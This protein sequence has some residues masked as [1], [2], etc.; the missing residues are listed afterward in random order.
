MQAAS[1]GVVGSTGQS[2][3]PSQPLVTLE[4][5]LGLMPPAGD[6]RG[7]HA[8]F[9]KAAL[10]AKCA[11]VRT[12]P[13]LDDS[14]LM[15]GHE[16]PQW[17]AQ[18]SCNKRN[19]VHCHLD[20]QNSSEQARTTKGDEGKPFASADLRSR[21]VSHGRHLLQ[22]QQASD[23]LPELVHPAMQD[24]AAAAAVMEDFPSQMLPSQSHLAAVRTHQQPAVKHEDTGRLVQSHDSPLDGNQPSQP[25]SLAHEQ[26]AGQTYSP[27][28]PAGLGEVYSPTV[29]AGLDLSMFVLSPTQPGP[30]ETAAL[31]PG[32]AFTSDSVGPPH[33]QH[34]GC[35]ND[36][37][38]AF[39]PMDTDVGGPGPSL[40]GRQDAAT[41]KEGHG[42]VFTDGDLPIPS[43]T[44]AVSS[45]APAES[46]LQQVTATRVS[47]LIITDSGTD[48]DFT[49]TARCSQQ[50]AASG[51]QPM[52]PGDSAGIN[53]PAVPA[54]TPDEAAMTTGG[55]MSFDRAVNHSMDMEPCQSKLADANH[56]TASLASQ[57]EATNAAPPCQPAP[58]SESC[59]DFPMLPS[60]EDVTAASTT[61][62]MANSSCQARGTGADQ[63]LSTDQ[64]PIH[65]Q[66][67]G[68][69]M[70][71][72]HAGPDAVDIPGEGQEAPTARGHS[73]ASAERQLSGRDQQHADGARPGPKPNARPCETRYDLWQLRGSRL[74][75]R[76]HVRAAS[77][78]VI[79]AQLLKA[80]RRSQC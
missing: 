47:S 62:G 64:G 10:L 5:P 24:T 72:P 77:S 34:I 40:Q 39:M 29:H 61:D 4:K 52:L 17:R 74:V 53:L 37:T 31:R 65:N 58:H 54:Q 22:R 68:S 38:P 27:S 73:A 20:T 66:V 76:S 69:A 15:L 50:V 51:C 57:C 79:A 9:Y 70:D 63:L 11:A 41:S 46:R 56:N 75:V 48:S 26:L 33:H 60:A 45:D 18:D 12:S 36:K 44:E 16:P 80:L 23:S 6:L 2:G 1:V 55:G 19:P 8:H 3:T 42:N 43:N 32:A 14:H 7:A 13:S 49:A 71:V 30:A 67:A 78:Q 21:Q 28:R 59:H 25:H 35:S